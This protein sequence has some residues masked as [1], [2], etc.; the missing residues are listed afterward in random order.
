MEIFTPK[1]TVKIHQKKD[2]TNKPNLKFNSTS[3]FPR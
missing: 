3:N 2:P 1:N